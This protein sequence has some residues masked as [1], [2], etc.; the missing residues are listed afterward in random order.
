MTS[1]NEAELRKIVNLKKSELKN[2]V[3]VQLDIGIPITAFFDEPPVSPETLIPA[4][5]E[6]DFNGIRLVLTGKNV[7][8]KTV[9]TSPIL[10]KF[11]FKNMIDGT[12]YLTLIWYKNGVWETETVPRLTIADAQK[13]VPLSSKGFPVTSMN[14]RDVVGFLYLLESININ[15][16]P[17]AEITSQIGW[18]G[19][20]GEKGFLFGLKHIPPDGKG[21]LMN[22]DLKLLDKKPYN[23]NSIFFYSSDEGDYKLA[24][25]FRFKGKY[26]KWLK[27]IDII[28]KNSIIAF[29]VYSGLAAPLL[30]LLEQ[31]N[32]II[33]ISGVTTSGKTTAMKVAASVFGNPNFLIRTW[34]NTQVYLERTASKH[35]GLP[36]L[37]DDTKLIKDK[38]TISKIIYE[39]TAGQ[40]R[41][42]GTIYGTASI[43]KWNTVILSTGESSILNLTNKSDGGAHGRVIAICS[44]PFPDKNVKN[45]KIIKELDSI[46]SKNYGRAG[47]K[48]IRYLLK[49]MKQLPQWKTEL[50]EIKKSYD[51]KESQ[52]I[53]NRLHGY[54]ACIH[55]AAKLFIEACPDCELDFENHIDTVYKLVAE[56]VEKSADAGKSALKDLYEYC[57]SHQDNFYDKQDSDKHQ[58]SR[59]WLGVW[60]DEC[61]VIPAVL[62]DILTKNGYEPKAIIRDW[63]QKGWLIKDKSGDNP[64]FTIGKERT[65]CYVIKA[66]IL[67][68]LTDNRL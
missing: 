6:I 1:R 42:R 45:M 18:V 28:N 62:S 35:M 43:P 51:K 48:Y 12:E 68:K 38:D 24:E 23:P 13:I 25:A 55:L 7:I 49:N 19:G 36:L 63:N 16:I 37:L 3:L 41:G 2:A 59:G 50:A 61:A 26:Q 47:I 40:G 56:D 39:G 17:Q 52:N 14:A 10:F 20:K 60:E 29:F 34:N 64:K 66:D 53:M 5:Y 4:G 21:D 67:S 58:P 22:A 32:F 57:V 11:R 54:F 46:I 65:R 27:I 31:P 8:N 33:D 30:K 15:N 9:S 44:P